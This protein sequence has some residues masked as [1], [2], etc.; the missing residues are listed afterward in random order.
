MT[1]AVADRVEL[2]GAHGVM[3]KRARTFRWAARLL[4]TTC[5]DDAAVLYAFCRAADDAA[6]E[7]TDRAQAVADLDAL[8]RSLSKDGDGPGRALAVLAEQRGMSLAPARELLA[9]VRQDTDLVRLADDAELLQYAYLVAGTVGLMMCGVLGARDQ[10][11][12]RYA[13]Q[14][15]IAMQITN[16]CRDV[17]EDAARGRVYLPERRLRAAGTSQTALL[18]GTAP[19]EAIA[20]VVSDLLAVADGFYRSADQGLRYLP[21]R[22]RLAVLMASRMYRAIGDVLRRRGCDPFLGRAVVSPLAKIALTLVALVSWVGL[23]V[24]SYRHLGRTSPRRRT[25]RPCATG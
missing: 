8:E 3:Q 11:A 18:A 6:D 10:R 7:A 5:R 13:I 15:G 20:K 16:I 25:E 21:S 17:A 12:E 9:G 24:R 23:A 22:A 14:L 19:K 1:Y 2:A 4:G